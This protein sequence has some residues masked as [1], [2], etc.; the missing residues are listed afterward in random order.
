[1]L[2]KVRKL[3]EK[4]MRRKLLWVFLCWFLALSAYAQS[5]PSA[6]VQQAADNMIAGLKENHATLKTKPQV[7]YGLAYK[8]IVPYAD[9]A[10]MAKQVLPAATWNKATAAQR[11]KFEQEFTKTLIRTY[12]SALSAY[13]DQ[14]IKVYPPRSVE[15]NTVEVNS[16]IV[17]S[18]SQPIHVSYRLIRNGA[19]WKLLDLSVEGVSMLESFRA[20]FADILSQGNMNDLLARMAGHNN[21]NG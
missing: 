9:T 4:F 19:S 3:E 10:A 12:A 7:V 18:E 8:Y 15:G 16:E 6:V 20:Q 14:T 17:S 5:G 1:M 13:T 21:R 2:G 11:E